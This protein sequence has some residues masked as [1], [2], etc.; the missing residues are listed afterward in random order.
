MQPELSLEQEELAEGKHV[1]ATR[2]A[3][4][5]KQKPEEEAGATGPEDAA[6]S[7]FSEKEGTFSGAVGDET[8]SAVQ[9]IQQVMLVRSPA[10]CGGL[11]CY[12]SPRG[13]LDPDRCQPVPCFRV[14]V[15]QCRPRG[16]RHRGE[17]QLNPHGWELAGTSLGGFQGPE[18]TGQ[19]GGPNPA[20]QG[21]CPAAALSQNFPFADPSLPGFRGPQ[22]SLCVCWTPQFS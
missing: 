14:S 13:D 22:L 2:R 21:V 9:S 17:K 7:E 11:T 6:F 20:E 3:P 16:H 10:G 12:P 4:K 8:D 15:S 18:C 19:A 1:K 5:R